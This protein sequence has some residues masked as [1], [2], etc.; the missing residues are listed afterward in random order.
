VGETQWLRK[1]DRFAFACTKVSRGLLRQTNPNPN[2]NHGQLL[3]ETLILLVFIKG[4]ETPRRGGF[5]RELIHGCY[6]T[7]QGSFVFNVRVPPIN[8]CVACEYNS[9]RQEWQSATL[10]FN[11]EPIAVEE[12]Q[13]KIVLEPRV[14]LNEDHGIII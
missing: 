1:R 10:S 13:H 6:A 4:E 12:L 9:S 8:W 14:E 5:Q 11:T 2:P 7:H 3:T